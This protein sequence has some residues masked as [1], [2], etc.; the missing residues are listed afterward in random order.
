LRAS[1]WPD[2]SV[3]APH[4]AIEEVERALREHMPHILR[5]VGHA[6]PIGEA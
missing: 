5:V 6:E 3:L 4:E 1:V 2:L